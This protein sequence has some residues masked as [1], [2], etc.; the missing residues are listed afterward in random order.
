[1]ATCV[2]RFSSRPLNMELGI[3]FCAILISRRQLVE[4][5]DEGDHAPLKRDSNHETNCKTK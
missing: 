3:L 4:L 2:S 5:G 1:L